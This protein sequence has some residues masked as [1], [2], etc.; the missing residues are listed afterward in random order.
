[1]KPAQLIVLLLLLSGLFRVSAQD[2]SDDQS[3]ADMIRDVLEFGI[4]E[5]VTGLF[6]DL[7][8]S[9]PQDLYQL[10][11]DRFS[12]ATFSKVKVE[13]IE[14]FASC[15][16]IPVYLLDA[17]YADAS[18]DP[19]DIKVHKALLGFLGKQGSVREGLLLI[20]RLDYGNISIDNAAADA[21]S[22][23]TDPGIVMPL[24]DRLK[25]SDRNDD[26]YINANIRSR[27]ILA[28]GEMKAE[29]AV[30]Y[31]EEILENNREDKFMLMYAMVSLGKIG[32]TTS[33]AKIA[34][35]LSHS[36][37]QVN[38]YAAYALSQYSDSAVVPYLKK[39]LRNNNEKIRISAMQ[40]L[41]KNS[42]TSSVRVF[43]YKFEKDPESSVKVEALKSLVLLGKP[44]IDGLKRFM[45]ERKYTPANLAAI[46]RTVSTDPSDE[47]VAFLVELYKDADKKGKETIARQMTVATDNKVDPVVK[48]ILGSDDYLIRIGALKIVY[49]IKA[50]TL[51]SD[52]RDIA[53]NDSVE[54]VRRNAKHYIEMHEM[55]IP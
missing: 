54:V 42:D 36:D 50:S 6:S 14:Y 40:G 38:E 43:L 44:G 37:K 55:R 39:M 21:L 48:L 16:N 52:V 24:L 12:E 30:P 11:L 22:K 46:A 19:A 29:Q 4:D 18:S 10:L 23:M 45:K 13:F 26:R 17:M 31:L 33:I 25:E 51:W 53:D 5:E 47:N 41:V 8:D 15:T 3:T 32:K 2:E 9:P 7:G 20:E 28:F 27:L 34:E 35:N 1:M 49:S